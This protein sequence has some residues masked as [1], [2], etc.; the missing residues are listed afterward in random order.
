MVKAR[1]ALKRPKETRS[2]PGR[3]PVVSSSANSGSSVILFGFI[4]L[5][6]AHLLDCAPQ[7][8]VE[9][10]TRPGIVAQ[11]FEL[12]TDVLRFSNRSIG[13]VAQDG[14]R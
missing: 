9:S 12:D 3:G 1:S 10:T 6:S 2:A 8:V 11:A 4:P 14:V 5:A 13:I 7:L